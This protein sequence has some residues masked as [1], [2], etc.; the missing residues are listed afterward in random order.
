MDKKEASL[1]RK[2]RSEDES[3]YEVNHV[4]HLGREELSDDLILSM[5]HDILEARVKRGSVISSPQT[6]RDF[7]KFE[8]RDLKHEEF[9]V[10]FLDNRHRVIH[11]ESLFRGTIDGA[12]VYPREVVVETLKHNAAAVIF[13]HNHP[14]GVSTPSQSDKDITARLKNAL[15]V[16]DVRVLDHLIVGDGEAYS[17]AEHGIL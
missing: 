11:M 1:V 13:A 17:F 5:A 8:F 3:S 2:I 15:A 7:L 12:S 6:T 16:I 4:T 14:S 10:M 9:F